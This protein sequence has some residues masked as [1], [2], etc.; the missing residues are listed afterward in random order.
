M[1]SRNP[2][3]TVMPAEVVGDDS[4]CG[5]SYAAKLLGMSV[6]TVQTLVEKGEIE[7]WKT[8]GG[9]RRI[10]MRSINQYIRDNQP[11][12]TFSESE[13]ATSLQILVV[14]DDENTREL[15]KA[16]FDE[17]NLPVD[18]SLMG[19]ALEALVDI[20]ALRPDLLITDLDMPGVDGF[21][22]LKVLRRNPQLAN[23]QVLVV[24]GMPEEAVVARGGLP[25]GTLFRQKPFNFDWL[26]G[27][28]TAL[29]TALRAAK[30]G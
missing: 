23:M 12:S 19:S 27:Y 14:E 25:P 3:E 17:W 24:T 7:A 18:C 9:H 5:T 26:Q 21:E 22:M 28:V 10:S 1:S 11:Q 2:P 20:A 30:G 16:C 29:L 8:R 4:Y 15:Y 13:P 6:A